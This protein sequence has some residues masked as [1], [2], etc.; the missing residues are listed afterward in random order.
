VTLQV[1]LPVAER[2]GFV[3]AVGEATGG[4]VVVV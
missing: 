2:D 3:V 1:T 4:E